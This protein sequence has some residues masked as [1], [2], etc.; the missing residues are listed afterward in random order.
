MSETPVS[1]DSLIGSL[2]VKDK[3]AETI[4]QH[5]LTRAP[6]QWRKL[7]PALAS[8]ALTHEE[9]EALIPLAHKVDP[10]YETELKDSETF[11]S[12]HEIAQ[13][14]FW[15]LCVIFAGRISKDKKFICFKSFIGLCSWG[16]APGFIDSYWVKGPGLC[17]DVAKGGHAGIDPVPLPGELQFDVWVEEIGGEVYISVRALFYCRFYL[18]RFKVLSKA[19]APAGK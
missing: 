17:T 15:H 10:K 9:V 14:E 19:I 3:E 18:K 1:L 13:I 8:V 11:V 2:S 7:F 6:A 5:D 12:F 16:I 4:T